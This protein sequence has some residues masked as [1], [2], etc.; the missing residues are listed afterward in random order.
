MA[1][2]CAVTFAKLGGWGWLGCA[3]RTFSPIFCTQI[4][5]RCVVQLKLSGILVLCLLCFNFFAQW[6]LRGCRVCEL[7]SL[8]AQSHPA[9]EADTSSPS[10]PRRRACVG[11]K[12]MSQA[13]TNVEKG[14]SG[15]YIMLYRLWRPQW[16]VVV[17]GGCWDR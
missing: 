15:F 9:Q 17:D 4:V 2:R 3:K 1:G 6:M 5:Q 10:R 7:P 14:I 16:L 8:T 12:E 11:P 13:V